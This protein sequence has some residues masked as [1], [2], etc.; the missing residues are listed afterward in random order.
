MARI[1]IKSTR[2]KKVYGTADRPRLAVYRSIKHIGGQLID[3]DKSVTLIS[4]I[5]PKKSKNNLETA[6]KLGVEIAQKAKGLGVKKIV[7]DRRKYLYHGKV[8][9][10][11]DG[12]REGGLEF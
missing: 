5:S 11:A 7:F 10:F 9:A 1:K 2:A 6:K 3:D 4:I 12:M 8:K